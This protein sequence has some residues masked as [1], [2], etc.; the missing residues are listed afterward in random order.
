MSKRKRKKEKFKQERLIE[1]L[2][3]KTFAQQQYIDSLDDNII[4]VATGVAGVG[5]TFCATY[6]ACQL[7]NDGW[8]D[9]IVLTRPYAHLGKDAGS[10][11]GTD[12]E[13]Y[14]PM[15]RPLLDVCKK[16]FGNGKYQY[17]IEKRIIEVA[18]LEKIQGRS[19][20]EDCA[21]ILDEAQNAT[22]PQVVSLMTRI[23]EGVDFLAI[24]GD[25]RQSIK[26][27]VMNTLD[28]TERF[29]LKYDIGETGIV[30]FTEEDCVRS[31]IVKEILM[32]LEEE[33]GYYT[34]LGEH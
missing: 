11:P 24:C 18:P 9:K 23:G 27:E 13:K 3:P 12:F 16:L 4:T 33:G 2:L 15:M 19:F 25:P 26:K 10:T 22:R 20:D 7:L 31:G 1:P 17:F 32:G 28:W 34:N 5:K 30:R 6:K 29:L 21:I 8:I 14:E